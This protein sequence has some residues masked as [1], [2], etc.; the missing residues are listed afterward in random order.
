[1]DDNF[2]DDELNSLRQLHNNLRDENEIKKEKE[3]E[4]KCKKEKEYNEDDLIA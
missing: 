3:W 1:M 2:I 4:D